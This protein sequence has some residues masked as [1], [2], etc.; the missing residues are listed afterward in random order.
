MWE[1]QTVFISQLE[2][3]QKAKDSEHLPNSELHAKVIKSSTDIV[4][5]DNSQCKGPALSSLTDGT[6]A[7]SGKTCQRKCD[8]STRINASKWEVLPSSSV[9]IL[10]LRSCSIS[11]PVVE[12]STRNSKKCHYFH[13]K[14]VQRTILVFCFTQTRR[15]SLITAVKQEPDSITSWRIHS[16][17]R[18]YWVLRRRNLPNKYLHVIWLKLAC[19]AVVFI[20]VRKVISTA[21]A[22]DRCQHHDLD[23]PCVCKQ[24]L[25][26]EPR[27]EARWKTPGRAEQPVGQ[28]QAWDITPANRLLCHAARGLAWELLATKNNLAFAKHICPYI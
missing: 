15:F 10:K 22:P 1:I 25:F 20:R 23:R 3:D 4:T 5:I 2:N 18:Q 17:S 12:S 8:D 14:L 13:T 27:R 26:G 16:H 11:V 9:R 7:F 6:P 24:V 19:R 21:P 28:I